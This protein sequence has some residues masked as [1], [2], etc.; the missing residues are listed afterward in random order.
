M[1]YSIKH[2]IEGCSGY[3]VVQTDSGKIVGCHPTKEGAAK[4]L[5]ALYSNVEDVK[6]MELTGGSGWKVEFGTPD[7]QDGWAV[8][9]SG[10]GQTIVCCKTEE[11]AREWVASIDQDSIDIGKSESFWAGAFDPSNSLGPVMG[12]MYQDARYPLLS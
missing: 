8:T 9:K 1:P 3:A 12:T 10:T 2:N 6:K 5:G 7:C 11:E 4:H